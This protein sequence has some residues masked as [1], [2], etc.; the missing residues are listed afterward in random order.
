MKKTRFAAKA[1]AGT[2]VATVLVLGSFS[3]PAQARPDT[4]W[5]PAVVEKSGP[6]KAMKDTGWG[7][8]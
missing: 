4:G 5:G 6:Y 8:V 2:L 1:L 3:A 7:P